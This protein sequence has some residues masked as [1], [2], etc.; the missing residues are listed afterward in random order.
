M[1]PGDWFDLLISVHRLSYITFLHLLVTISAS[2]MSRNSRNTYRALTVAMND[3]IGTVPQDCYPVLSVLLPHILNQ[4]IDL[5]AGSMFVIT[6]AMVWT[7]ISIVITYSVVFI[8][9]N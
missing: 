4:S 9:I 7:A 1:I 2:N 6:S 3:N 5:N 8:T